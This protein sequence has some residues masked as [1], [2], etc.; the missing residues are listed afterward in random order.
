MWF[1]IAPP[2]PAE[3][4]YSSQQSQPDRQRNSYPPAEAETKIANQKALA[5]KDESFAD[6]TFG[7]ACFSVVYEG[8]GAACRVTRFASL[9]DGASTATKRKCA[10]T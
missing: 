2:R 10:I 1:L 9:C 8:E 6:A 4:F 5:S 3:S 7:Y